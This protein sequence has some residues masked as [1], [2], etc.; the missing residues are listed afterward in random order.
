MFCNQPHHKY[1]VSANKY[2]DNVVLLLVD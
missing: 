1:L 2:R